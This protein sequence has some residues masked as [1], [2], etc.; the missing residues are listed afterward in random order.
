MA[1]LSC[2]SSSYSCTWASCLE[3][4]GQTCPSP[5]LS[6]WCHR[7]RWESNVLHLVI[8]F[9]PSDWGRRLQLCSEQ[10]WTSA[11]PSRLE[12]NGNDNCCFFM[13]CLVLVLGWLT[14]ICFSIVQLLYLQ[15]SGEILKPNYNSVDMV[16]VELVD[17]PSNEEPRQNSS[18][19]FLVSITILPNTIKEWSSAG[20]KAILVFSLDLSSWGERWWTKRQAAK[21]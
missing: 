6:S 18:E 21:G 15:F 19:L 9:S 14:W 3:W 2:L 17:D 8:W 12:T 10:Q 5:R 16:E 20:G 7:T 13:G 4:P 1:A 11:L